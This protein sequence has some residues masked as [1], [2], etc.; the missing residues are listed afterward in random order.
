MSRLYLLANTF[1]ILLTCTA[2]VHPVEC[3]EGSCSSDTV[4]YNNFLLFF[5]FLFSQVR[6]NN[7]FLFL[8]REIGDKYSS[9][10]D[11]VTDKSWVFHRLK[12]FN[13]LGMVHHNRW[14]LMLVIA[15]KYIHLVPVSSIFSSSSFCKYKP[16]TNSFKFYLF[17]YK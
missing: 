7:N 1:P 9:V 15:V 11:V 13:L 4:I 5:Y 3:T 14:H 8:L 12:A 6:S 2:P 17:R 16:F 10:F